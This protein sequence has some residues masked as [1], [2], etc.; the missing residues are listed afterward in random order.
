MENRYSKIGIKTIVSTLIICIVIGSILYL[1]LGI[2]EGNLQY[3][4]NLRIPKLIGIIITGF[5]ISFS[6]MLF[7]NTTN[8]RLL[9]P[10]IVGLD[11]FYVLI[12]TSIVFLL[13]SSHILI[14]NKNINFFVYVSLMVLFSYVLFNLIFRKEKSNIF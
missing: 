8:N 4:L 9:T 11:Y 1:S 3:S 7:Q 10:N 6:T 14:T 5:L 12:Q 2:K 13:G